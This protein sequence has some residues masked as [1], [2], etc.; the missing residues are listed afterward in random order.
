MDDAAP[1]VAE[2]RMFAF[3]FTPT[4]WHLCDGGPLPIA[5]HQPLFSMLGWRFGG[6]GWTTF[7]LPDLR[8]E[9][10]PPLIQAIATDGVLAHEVIRS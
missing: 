6:D 9:T 4:G 1:I 3:G 8:A 7:A 2:I 5:E 10:A